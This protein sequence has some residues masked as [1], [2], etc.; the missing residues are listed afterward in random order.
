MYIENKEEYREIPISVLNLSTRSF[1]CLMR[2][3]ISTLYL[4]I[5]NV[6]KLKEI[7]STPAELA[8]IIS[9]KD[10]AKFI[11]AFRD[12][13]KEVLIMQTF[14]EFTWEDVAEFMPQQMYEDYK[15]W[16]LTFYD[17]VQKRSEAEKTSILDD[18]D[19]TIELIQIDKINVAYIINLMK[20]ID[21]SNKKQQEDDIK[22][23]HKELNRATD[24]ELRRK[25]ELIK[26]FLADVIPEINPDTDVV[27]A[28]SD[29]ENEE[30]NKEINEFIENNSLDSGAFKEAISE[31]EFSEKFA[32]DKIKNSL[33]TGLKFMERKSLTAKIKDFIKDNC[34]KYR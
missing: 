14:S 3:N 23:I 11:L 26:A 31:Y 5:E 29:Y 9:E 10:K 32:D 22:N 25:I 20:N 27:E 34:E 17:E 18:I 21:L 28:Y 7:A 24:P 1:N 8:S 30:R 6:E 19:F 16:Y 15:S 33:P 12:L 2:A 13:S 4:L